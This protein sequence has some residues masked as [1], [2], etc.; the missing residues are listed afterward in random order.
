[1]AKVR[2][3]SVCTARSSRITD[4]DIEKEIEMQTK[5][6]AYQGKT[7]VNTQM[8]Q[9]QTTPSG[10]QTC[11]I[12]ITWEGDDTDPKFINAQKAKGCYVATAVYGSYDCSEVW[13][14][15]RYRDLVLAKTLFGRM[16]IKVYY[17]VS[18]TIVRLFGG[19]KWFKCF[20]KIK[21]DKLV[22]KLKDRGFKD[23]PYKD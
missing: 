19:T 7:I 8:G 10:E 14:L 2:G 16:F 5:Y 21:L 1:M 20:W 17:A 22:K 4:R 13:I 12:T 6:L 18:P 23:T 15:R 9:I 3:T 11:I